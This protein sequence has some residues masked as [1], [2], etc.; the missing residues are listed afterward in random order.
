MYKLV[1][2]D[3]ITKSNVEDGVA[4]ALQKFILNA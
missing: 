3:Y 2:A 4:Y 1:A